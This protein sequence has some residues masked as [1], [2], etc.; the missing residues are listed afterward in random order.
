[1]YKLYF[2]AVLFVTPITGSQR[3][4]MI[5]QP[6]RDFGSC[7]KPL[8][9]FSNTTTVITDPGSYIT[10]NDIAFSPTN[11]S[12]PIIRISSSNVHINFNT[13]SIRIA[14]E[15]S[16]SGITDGIII[17]NNLSN[18]TI[19]NGVINNLTGTGIIT[20]EQCRNIQIVDMAITKIGQAGIIFKTGGSNIIVHNC[21][22]GD[23]TLISGDIYGIKFTSTNNVKIGSCT[24]SNL[25]TSSSSN[26]YGIDVTGGTNY[27]IN[28]TQINNNRA[29]GVSGIRC[30]NTSGI[31]INN[32]ETKKNVGSTTQTCGIEFNQVSTS[33]INSCET[34]ANTSTLNA[35]GILFTN[36]CTCNEICDTTS[37]SQLSIG[38]G[39]GHG[40]HLNGGNKNYIK[41]CKSFGNTGGSLSTSIGSGI[42]LQS[43]TKTS[44]ENS[45]FDYNHGTTGK[46]YGMY[47]LGSSLCTIKNNRFYHNTGTGGGWGIFEDATSTSFIIK[48]EAFANQTKNYIIPLASGKFPYKE[49]DIKNVD[50][51]PNMTTIDNL[52]ITL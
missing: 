35:C 48:N 21:F 15:S 2:L 18:I 25:E 45:L 42:I 41:N 39:N 36:K 24:L 30:T 40:I 19:R 49:V 8:F 22:I 20:G 5:G 9:I 28:N 6:G 7:V 29:G 1:M 10:A 14:P 3:G 11:S 52:S 33:S 34:F 4:A 26:C 23:S 17:D 47:L 27:R 43:E 50:D 37:S 38:S 46:G 44:I 12:I 31:S 51:L 16:S 13:S 32:S